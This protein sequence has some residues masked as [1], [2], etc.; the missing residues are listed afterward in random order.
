MEDQFLN[1][2]AALRALMK[3]SS[4]SPASEQK[5][6][7]KSKSS[8]VD[9]AMQEAK[10]TLED[11]AEKFDKLAKAEKEQNSVKIEKA[12]QAIKEA[13]NK[14]PTMGQLVAQLLIG[15]AP[16]AL[17]YA[18]AGGLGITRSAGGLA[19]AQAGMVGA[20]AFG[21]SMEK[22]RQREIE[23]AKLA[24]KTTAEQ[25]LEEQAQ[26]TKQRELDIKEL[27][28][29][30]K[31]AQGKLREDL[32]KQKFAKGEKVKEPAGDQ[33]KAATF[34]RRTEQAEEVMN[35]LA[36]KGFDR[37][38]P[39]ER[40]KKYLPGELIDS[41]RLSQDQA[42]RNF[43]NA[44]LRRE[45]GAA[46]SPSEFASAEKQYFPRPG[47][48]PE[49]VKQKK[50]NRLQAIAGLQGEAGPVALSR[51]P[52]V[53]EKT[54]TQSPQ[55]GLLSNLGAQEAVAAPPVPQFESLSDD[56]LDK[57]LME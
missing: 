48:S 10:R 49:V 11:Q 22:Q 32:L 13:E 26:K 53:T 34:A 27:E 6:A 21:E 35:A 33:F 46:I 38:K 40:L 16:T 3:G 55:G 17:G 12:Y 54:L 50:L 15:F 30:G 9:A 5:V 19:G 47:D 51:V 2:K 45:S 4:P 8:S 43:V 57:F 14:E 36:E 29:K 52:L 20:K 18:A 56:E 7:E 23:T 41:D 44:V 25:A 28:A 42:E 1:D 31:L 37:T 24:Y 39:V